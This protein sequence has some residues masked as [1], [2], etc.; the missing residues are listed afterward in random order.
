M[1]V[2]S[3]KLAAALEQQN[4]SWNKLISVTTDRSPNLASRKPRRVKNDA[5]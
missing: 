1:C 5:Q 2:T 3:E 4:L